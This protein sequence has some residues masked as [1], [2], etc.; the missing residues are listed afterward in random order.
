MGVSNS[1]KVCTLKCGAGQ[2][3]TPADANA[4]YRTSWTSLFHTLL[5][6]AHSTTAFS[7]TAFCL[8]AA[9]TRR[10]SAA[11]L[12]FPIDRTSRVSV[13]PAQHLVMRAQA[14]T[15][16]GA[17]AQG[18]PERDLLITCTLWSYVR[19]GSNG[20]VEL[21]FAPAFPAQ[22]RL[23]LGTATHGVTLGLFDCFSHGTL[24]PVA[25]G[26]AAVD[27]AIL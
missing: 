4:G 8:L 2:Q 27:H 3:C 23:H 25:T 17:N 6:I 26:F 19:L 9:L 13:A 15:G 20:G 5:P 18:L 16:V 1:G 7:G 14:T 22:I 24:T 10:S 21:A 11:P 12:K